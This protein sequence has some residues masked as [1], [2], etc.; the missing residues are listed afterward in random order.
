M[1]EWVMVMELETRMWWDAAWRT[2]M[3]RGGVTGMWWD[4]VMVVMMAE[5]RRHWRGCQAEAVVVVGLAVVDGASSRMRICIQTV[6]VAGVDV[7]R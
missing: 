7:V 1:R 6:G 5:V 2:A 4:V 3:V